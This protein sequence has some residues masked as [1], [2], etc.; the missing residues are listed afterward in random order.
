PLFAYHGGEI[1]R[2][3]GGPRVAGHVFSPTEVLSVSC[4]SSRRAWA[5]T[6][7]LAPAVA[8][9]PHVASAQNDSARNPATQSPNRQAPAARQ[10]AGDAPPAPGGEFKSFEEKLSYVLGVNTARRMQ[11]DKVEPDPQSFARGFIDTF[12]NK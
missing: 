11:L 2:R 6:L 3:A 9:A 4:F 10:A 7:L 8:C 5:F 12:S 1:G